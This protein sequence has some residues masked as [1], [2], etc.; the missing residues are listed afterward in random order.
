M[1]ANTDISTCSC[2]HTAPPKCTAEHGSAVTR[3]NDSQGSNG[4]AKSSALQQQID[5]TEYC[6]LNCN[7]WQRHYR[8][9][10][11]Q[12]KT[13]KLCRQCPHKQVT[14]TR[15]NPAYVIQ[16]RQGTYARV[17]DSAQV[18]LAQ[19]KQQMTPTMQ[20]N[21]HWLACSTSNHSAAAEARYSTNCG[22]AA[23]A[24]I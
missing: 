5:I 24:C 13:H 16:L 4:T 1:I 22:S 20:R 9:G 14:L 6:R 10:Y 23:A 17:C 3:D 11:Q 21:R 2:M 18:N 19:E 12:P 7:A 15:G 8:T